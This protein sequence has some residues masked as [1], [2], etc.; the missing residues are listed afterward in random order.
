MPSVRHF[1]TSSLLHF[2][3]SSLRHFSLRHSGIAKGETVKS[4]RIAF[5]ALSLA[6]AGVSVAM[7]GGSVD[8]SFRGQWVPAKATCESP[9]KVVI[10]ANKVTFVNGAQRAEYSKLEQCFS[11]AGRDVDHIIWLNSDAMGDSPWI[12]HLDKKKSRSS[13]LI[14]AMTRSLGLASVG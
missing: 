8:P 5:F 2:F 11:C 6:A 10:D 4:L 14:S 13:K 1:F 12:L 7:T 9:V 3:T